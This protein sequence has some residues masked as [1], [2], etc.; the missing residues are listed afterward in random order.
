LYGGLKAAGNFRERA[1]AIYKMTCRS[2]NILQKQ[3]D[4]SD[5]IPI[6]V[7]IDTFFLTLAQK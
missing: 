2:A 4:S 3:P 7:S 6:I 5:K 1:M